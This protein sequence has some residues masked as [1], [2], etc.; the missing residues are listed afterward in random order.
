MFRRLSGVGLPHVYLASGFTV[1][2]EGDG[3]TSYRELDGLY[4]AIARAIAMRPGRLTGAEL[5]FLRKRMN[6]SQAQVG[7]IVGKTD[8]VVAKWEKGQLPVPK[9]DGVDIRLRWL[10]EARMASD[11]ARAARRLTTAEDDDGS[12]YVF[13]FEGQWKDISTREVPAVLAGAATE[14]KKPATQAVRK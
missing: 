2:S 5:R 12:Q 11:L 13:A 8:Q 1:D 10:V 6:L 3:A 9:A 4:I 14:Q 7:E